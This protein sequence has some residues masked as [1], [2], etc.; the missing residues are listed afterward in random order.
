MSNSDQ[1]LLAV[2][3]MIVDRNRDP[4]SAARELD[5]ETLVRLGSPNE[6]A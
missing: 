5:D 3:I 4:V 1:L 2:A 6:D